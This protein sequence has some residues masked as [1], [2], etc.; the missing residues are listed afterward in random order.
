[1]SVL[2]I[3]D[4]GAT[5]D[6]IDDDTEAIQS[7]LSSASPGDMVYFPSGTYK[8]TNGLSSS[9]PNIELRGEGGLGQHTA[10]GTGSTVIDCRGTIVGFTFN[11]AASSTLFQGPVIRNMTFNGSSS[12]VGG[13]LVKRA[14]NW[15]IESV[16][17]TGFTTGHGIKSDGT[18]G[19]SQYPQL[20]NPNVSNCLIG[21]D[22]VLTNGLRVFGGMIDANSNSGS[23][24]YGTTGVR[25]QSGDS[26][27]CIG[28]VVQ[29]AETG[30]DL[31]SSGTTYH[32]LIGNRTEGCL[33]HYKVAGDRN[34][35]VGNTGTNSIL[36][37][38][39][40]FVSL[41]STA[42]RNVLVGCQAASLS[43][44]VSD[45]GTRNVHTDSTTQNEPLLCFGSGT[46]RAGKIGVGNSVSAVSPQSCV[47]K[48]QVFD[49]S[50]ASIGYIPV[51]ND[52][53]ND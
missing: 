6:G 20:V 42:D 18:G 49:A 50:G 27:R 41:L 29:Y 9:V 2:N 3:S 53:T 48:I 44:Y 47:R 24:A 34:T 10:V 25:V 31:Q 52:I 13:I 15:I 23:I 36:G 4:Y 32:C 46:V 30:F 38:G 22:Q 28:L 7:A 39:G 19:V 5:G 1:M 17:V 8:I 33:T 14:N 16:S 51:Y 45:A 21:I 26:L 35:F 11:S 12:G 40:V 37:G 43:S